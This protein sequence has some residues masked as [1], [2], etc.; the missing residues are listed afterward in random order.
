M[1]TVTLGVLL[2]PSLAIISLSNEHNDDTF[3]PELWSE[4]L[5]RKPLARLLLGGYFPATAAHHS[6]LGR[7][8]TMA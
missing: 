8:K 3:P 4:I 6:E 1:D 7:F 5:L 2:G